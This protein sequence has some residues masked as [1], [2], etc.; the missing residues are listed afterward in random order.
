MATF[1]RSNIISHSIQSLISGSFQDWELIVIGDACTD[2]TARII[3]HINDPRIRFNNLEQNCGEQSGPNNVGADMARGEYLA[4][5]NHDDLWLPDHLARSIKRLRE[6]DADLIFSQGL[7][8]GLDGHTHSI[9]GALCKQTQPYQAWMSVPATL[10]LMRRDLILRIGPW[11]RANQIRTAPSQDWLYRAHRAGA[12][13]LADPVLSAVLIHSG[14]RNNSYSNRLDHEHTYWVERLKDPNCIRD[15]L[16]GLTGESE[17]Q[18]IFSPFSNAANLFKSFIRKTMLICGFFPPS[19][20]YWLK[21]C[22][23]GSFLRD[24]RRTRGLDPRLPND[25]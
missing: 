7:A 18:R 22:R 4:F 9:C 23:K 2:D 16:S 15:I 11:L 21:Y 3:N 20:K 5:L 24:L 19:P 10:W 1:N 6:T 13:L 17:H 12:K 14:N 25:R 8:I